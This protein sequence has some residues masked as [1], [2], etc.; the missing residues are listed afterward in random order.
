MKFRSPIKLQNPFKKALPSTS[1]KTTKAGKRSDSSKKEDYSIDADI[2]LAFFRSDPAIS[3]A[4]WT[5][6]DNI[7]PGYDILPTDDSSEAEREVEEATQALEKNNWMQEMINIAANGVVFSNCYQEAHPFIMENQRQIKTYIMDTQTIKIVLEEKGENSG[8]VKSYDQM[9]DGKKVASLDPEEV[10]HYMTNPFGD[11]DK[12]LSLVEACLFSA[13][14]RKFI[15]KFNGSIF[16]NH[17][18]RGVWNFSTDM[19]DPTYNDNVD[20]II[21]AKNHPN[22][23]IFLRGE[24]DMIGFQSFLSQQ[25]TAF[26]EAYTD[27]RDEIL[28]AMRVPKF[29][30]IGGSNKAGGD[31]ELQ[32]FDRMIISRQTYYNKLVTSRL[33]K[34]IMGFTKIKFVLQKANRRDEI[35]ELEIMQKMSGI[36]T[37]NEARVQIGLPELDEDEFPQANQIW[38]VGQSTSGVDSVDG[39]RDAEEPPKGFAK[40]LKKNEEIELK[41]VNLKTE[42]Q[43]IALFTKWIKDLRNVAKKEIKESRIFEKQL[44]PKNI[45][46]VLFASITADVLATNYTQA[47][48]NQFFSG[49]DQIGDH[50]GKNFQP[51]PEELKFL[52]DYNFDQVKDLS[53]KTQT[54]LRNILRR[55]LI[56]GKST[57]AVTKEVMNELDITQRNAET[58]TRTELNRINSNGAMNAIKQSGLDAKKYLLITRDDRTSQISKEFEKKYG[59]PEQAIAIDKTFKITL[60]GKTFEGLVPPFHP[61]DR[62]TPIF[63]FE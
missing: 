35:R 16:E 6:T 7:V 23:D 39:Q 28:M 43:T 25:D 47:I 41:P 33:L 57:S 30:L 3:A 45:S 21:E 31:V 15:D 13:A 9:I 56:D 14:V 40:A 51:N 29:L 18:P 52:E 34:D 36:V 61:N 60:R 44:D 32:N 37:L 59:T 11:R 58:L 54:R 46:D 63:I 19:D 42:A 62:D 2:L 10:I 24:K 48:S 4:T 49:M 26:R 55:G 1:K 20:L 50:L 12:G 8:E 22:K 53:D 5:T 17:K 27:A 38:N